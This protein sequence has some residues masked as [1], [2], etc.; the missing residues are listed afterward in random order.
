MNNRSLCA[1]VLAT[2][3]FLMA[4]PIVAHHGDAGR[5][6]ETP[7]IVTG[8]VAEIKLTNPHSILVFDVTDSSGKVVRWQAEM[9]GGN[10]LT[11]QFG[12]SKD[13]PKIGEKV[14]LNGRKVKSGAPYMNMTEKAQIVLTDS[15]KEIFRTM[16]FGEP[17]PA[18]KP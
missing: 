17:A 11:K 12:W 18:A 14:T 4:A 1:A 2:G 15:G 16:N 8:T 6:D 10:Q 7:F 5:Y 3:L 13:M 9:G